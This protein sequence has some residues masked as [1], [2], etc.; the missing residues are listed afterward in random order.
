MDRD[1][2]R[3]PVLIQEVPQDPLSYPR[4]HSDEAE[5]DLAV[6]DAAQ[7]RQV[8]DDRIVGDRAGAAVSPVVAGA[9]RVEWQLVLT[10]NAN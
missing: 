8:D 7:A 2:K 1:K 9:D 3:V 10:G 6:V 5:L 4:L